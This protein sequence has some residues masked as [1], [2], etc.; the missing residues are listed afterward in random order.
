MTLTTI[1]RVLKCM[2]FCNN[3]E[4]N[5]C[6]ECPYVVS[7]DD[8]LKARDKDIVKV[9]T[10]CKELYTETP[11]KASAVT[12]SVQSG[13]VTIHQKLLAVLQCVIH[14]EITDAAVD[15]AKEL[16]EQFKG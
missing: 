9:L 10:A 11:E 4:A 13:P 2:E 15:I 6:S 16:Y 5:D 14:G 1:E 12:Y 3:P 8:C 7:E